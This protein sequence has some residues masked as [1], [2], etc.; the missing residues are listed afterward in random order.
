MRCTKLIINL[1]DLRHN[2][3]EIKK[4]A[5][6][7]I[8]VCAS[9][10]ADAYGHGAVNCAKE[11]ESC[12]IDFLAV[13]TVDEGVELRKNGIKVPILMLSL[14]CPEEVC[15]AVKNNLTPLVFDEEYID[16]FEKAA[17]LENI[18][19]FSVHLAVDSGMGRIGCMPEQAGTLAVYIT[20]KTHLALGGICTHFASSDSL[21]QQDVDYTLRQLEKFNMA[22]NSVEK[23]GINPGIRHC[24]SSAA[25]L[26]LPSAK[27]DMIRAGL[28]LYGYYPSQITGKYLASVGRDV[29]LK[30]VMTFQT[31]VAA[32]RPFKKGQSVSYGHTWTASEDTLI[33][34]LPV[35][36]AD[37]LRRSF[38]PGIKVCIN[39]KLYPVCGRI[40]MDQ[41]M[42]N[43]GKDNT[44]VKRWDKAVIFGSCPE[45]NAMTADDLAELDSTISYEIMTGISKRVPRETLNKSY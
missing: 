37:G 18:S 9:V 41:C 45:G 5:G 16:L 25:S 3:F 39:G 23:A 33:A 6:G 38:S 32:I 28:I 35:G 36:Y 15:I 31:E 22:C 17:A 30:K 8:K 4:N 7:K 20:G 11:L 42:V 14:C 19:G 26:N 10:K 1:A 44:D 12:G 21:T 34:V 27:F 24:S 43:I 29:N 13:A 2:F 40:C